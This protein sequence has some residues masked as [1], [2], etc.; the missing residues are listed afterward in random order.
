MFHRS[1]ST[2]WVEGLAIVDEG[3]AITLVSGAALSSLEIPDDHFSSTSVVVTTID[4]TMPSDKQRM[5]KGLRM[6]PLR[7]PTACTE[8]SS[9]VE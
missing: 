5:V 9:C 2:R 8:I 3:S 6:Y 7:N 4:R 1:D